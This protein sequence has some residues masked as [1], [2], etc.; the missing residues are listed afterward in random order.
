MHS[1]FRYSLFLLILFSSCKLI[2]TRLILGIKNPKIESYRSINSFLDKQNLDKLHSFVLSDSI[3]IGLITNHQKYF[4]TYEVYDASMKKLILVDSLKKECYGSITKELVYL[5]KGSWKEDT[6]GPVKLQNLLKELKSTSNSIIPSI[7]DKNYN[8]V[9]Y[10]S[11]FMGKYTKSILQIA[12]E[13][14]DNPNYNI[15][16]INMDINDQMSSDLQ[17]LNMNIK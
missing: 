12:K 7:A 5:E 11:K 1:P 8:I 14:E 9:F 6:A 10:W 2:H 13:I 16:F 3:Y 17:D 4:A 15:M